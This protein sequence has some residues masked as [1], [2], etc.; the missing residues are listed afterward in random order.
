MEITCE[1]KI[2]VISHC[3]DIQ[4]PNMQKLEEHHV[5]NVCVHWIICL[6]HMSFKQCSR[7]V[8]C[9]QSKCTYLKSD[10]DIHSRRY[11]L[12]STWRGNVQKV[13]ITHAMYLVF[14]SL[15]LYVKCCHSFSP[16]YIFVD[17][18]LILLLT[19]HAPNTYLSLHS[20]FWLT[21]DYD[22]TYV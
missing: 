4:L 13:Y 18:L 11:A 12:N 8:S 21:L 9:L 20:W 7:C 5:Q 2:D 14:K 19:L 1:S 16:F 17:V 10:N 22:H 3:A 15:V 6:L